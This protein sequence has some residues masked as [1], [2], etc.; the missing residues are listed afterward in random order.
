MPAQYTVGQL[1]VM[2]I[3]CAAGNQVAVN[4][5]H[6]LITTSVALG[7]NLEDIV[8]SIGTDLATLYK[9]CMGAGATYR[10]YDFGPPGLA[11]EQPL[12]STQ[13]QG[14]GTG[15]GDILPRNTS[16][17]IHFGSGLTGRANRG[18]MY[19]AFPPEGF[20]DADGHP[21]AGYRLAADAL[22]TYLA[23]PKSIIGSDG[24]GTITPVIHHR[25]GG[26]VTPITSSKCR[27]LWAHQDRRADYGRPNTIPF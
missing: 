24:T 9:P 19:V 11:V 6:W 2:R 15:T 22:G 4:I 20:N 7:L 10:G 13:G 8:G 18:R 16:G 1:F 27:S 5:R 3:Y 25:A 21:T 17:L 23:E 14:A 26:A 12:I